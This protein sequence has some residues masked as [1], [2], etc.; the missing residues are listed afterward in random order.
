M[1]RTRGT[2][3]RL[4]IRSAQAKR[5][6]AIFDQLRVADLATFPRTS[7]LPNFSWLRS[8][9][10]AVWGG[11]TIRECLL[12]TPKKQAKTTGGALLFL[13]AFLSD[14][15][16]N[17]QYTILAPSVG[18][19]ALAFDAIHGAIEADQTLRDL[20]H[21]RPYV[22]EIESRKTGSKLAVK[23][24]ER[25]A[26]TGLKG[27]ILL[28]ESWLLGEKAQS[29]KLRAQIRG[30]LAASPT[31]KILHITTTSDDVPRGTWAEL[32]AYARSV[33]D[34]RVIA[35]GFL[36]VIYEPWPGCDPWTDETAWP[37]LLPSFPHIADAAF[38]R[39]VI[40]EANQSG[41]DAV[42]R[43][44]A[45]FF[46]VTAE[47]AMAGADGWSVA[48]ILAS[49]TGRLT[50][51]DLFRQADSIAAGIDL[52]GLSDL[53]AITF[54]GLAPDRSWLVATRCWASP[55]VW[56]R[57]SPIKTALPDFMNDGDL[58]PCAPG[59]DL[60]GI[61]GLLDQARDTGK[62]KVVGIDPAGASQLADELDQMPGFRVVTDPGAVGW[63]GDVPVIG[64]SRSA[65][66]LVTPIRTFERMAEAGRVLLS[67][68][69]ILGWSL[70]NV[71]LARSGAAEY[72]DRSRQSEK[73]DPVA[74]LLDAVAAHGIVPEQMTAD[75]SA[76]IG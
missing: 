70:A 13:A 7:D 58:I 50:E 6:G 65:R 39:S 62:P 66:S 24:F 46:N 10:T 16:P 5:F 28:D 25:S 76:W 69:R 18:I 74:A 55:S 27:S 40:A 68:Q 2:C 44:K 48:R 11:N 75:V 56:E 23:A 43:D 26:A 73:I 72:L 59:D 30:A 8:V 31:A 71:R 49:L 14:Q 22:R 53:S 21:V 37:C 20:L 35:P 29:H 19:A 47:T 33:R 3:A 15:A 52:G 45:Q 32:L 67:D 64:I 17:Q 4:P 61:L 42:A 63:S 54:L 36:P 1:C 38:Y 12:T 51:A 57:N 60:P 34:G 41:P 9:G